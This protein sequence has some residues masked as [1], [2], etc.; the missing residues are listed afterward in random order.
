MEGFKRND[1]NVD[2]ELRITGAGLDEILRTAYRNVLDTMNDGRSS[3]AEDGYDAMFEWRNFTASGIETMNVSASAANSATKSD[4]DVSLLR[5]FETSLLTM[6]PLR[7][8]L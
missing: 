7:H 8:P 2:A 5:L 1:R 4:S 6:L 3:D